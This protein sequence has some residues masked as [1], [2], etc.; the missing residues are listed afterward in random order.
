MAS[1]RIMHR[2]CEG[3]GM[4]RN[5]IAMGVLSL[6]L[7]GCEGV[8]D[9]PPAVVNPPAHGAIVEPMPGPATMTMLDLEP[10]PP[11][12][13]APLPKRKPPLRHDE[14]TELQSALQRFGYDPGPIDGLL[15]PRTL[16]A[17]RAYKSATGLPVDGGVSYALLLRLRD[18]VK[19]A[20]MA[21]ES[22]RDMRTAR[23]VEPAAGS[24]QPQPQPGPPQDQQRQGIFS[25]FF[26]PLFGK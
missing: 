20:E 4:I 6:A 8:F 12:P 21:D 22:T 10:S 16:A 18:Q 14:M 5:A 24:A 25:R 23:S 7:A 3:D 26:G 9:D 17:I 15:G 2:H 19:A 11:L 1:A 13:P